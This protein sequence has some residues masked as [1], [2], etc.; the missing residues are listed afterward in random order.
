MTPGVGGEGLWSPLHRHDPLLHRPAAP[1]RPEAAPQSRHRWRDAVRR[2]AEAP[3]A[4]DLAIAALAAARRGDDPRKAIGQ[5]KQPDGVTLA[6]VWAAYC[7]AG[8]PKL[9]GTAHKRPTTIRKD[10]DRFN[11]HLAG[12][13]GPTAIA[14]IDTP[15]VRRWLDRIATEGA[16]SHALALLKSLLSF[17]TTRGIATAHRIDIA[18][19]PSRKVANYFKPA[20]L[21][22]LD[23]TL[24]KLIRD[25]PDRLLPF[26][27]LRVLLAT[28]AR[29]IEIMSLRW[30]D[31]DLAE[32]VIRL[33]RHKGDAHS[34]K[35]ILLTPAAVAALKAVPKTSSPFVFFSPYSESGHVT[36]I[37]AAWADALK[38]AGLRKVRP[39]DLRHSFASA[40]IGKDVSPV[41]HREAAR[42]QARHHDAALRASGARRGAVRARQ[43]GCCTWRC[44]PMSE[45]PAFPELPEYLVQDLAM[46]D[47][48]LR[49]ACR[50]HL[51]RRRCAAR[52]SGDAAMRTVCCLQQGDG[53]FRRQAARQSGK[54]H[55][56]RGG[57]AGRHRLE[58][59]RRRGPCCNAD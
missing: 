41:R 28:G 16:R 39:Y 38:A 29:P 34:G 42:P 21:A 3:G 48:A 12:Q 37:E 23:R 2:A 36:K 45:P 5:R 44:A 40:A 54:E 26:T 1:Q 52:R 18:C 51:E 35:D 17:S 11:C 14:H 59:A 47:L 43:G 50:D 9:K 6:D 8:H 33:D 31:L 55:R 53:R 20:E 56:P 25:N 32:Q 46:L 10:T 49:R 15:C 22:K 4:R 57:G 27:V 58:A 30:A 19:S 24:V 13:L 7:E